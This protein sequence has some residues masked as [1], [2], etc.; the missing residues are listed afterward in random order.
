MQ[1]ISSTSFEETREAEDVT[2]SDYISGVGTE[3]G[4][5]EEAGRVSEERN[6]RNLSS[7]ERLRDSQPSTDEEMSAAPAA[8]PS[9]LSALVDL[10]PIGRA[11]L[12]FL[13]PSPSPSLCMYASFNSI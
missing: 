4:E 3:K 2:P 5:G 7:E 9:V 11:G 1:Y 13:V 12:G 8:V 10:S 6:S